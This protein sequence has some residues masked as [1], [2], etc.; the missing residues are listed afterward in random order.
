MDI[1]VLKKRSIALFAF[2]TIGSF[3]LKVLFC[4]L[5]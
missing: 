1:L 4:F 2:I 3:S 5:A